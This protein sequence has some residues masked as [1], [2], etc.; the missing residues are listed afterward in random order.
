MYNIN[1]LKKFSKQAPDGPAVRIA[2]L[3]DTATQ[4]LVTAL[5]GTAF[6]RGINADIY[7]AGYDQV[8][9]EI[10]NEGSGL[11]RF[12][13]DHTIIYMSSEKLYDEYCNTPLSERSG[14]A[15][16]TMSGIASQWDKINSVIQTKIMQ[17]NFAE[18]NDMIFGSL[19]SKTEESYIY[20][21]RK[22]NYLLMEKASKVRNAYIVDLSGIQ[23]L[24]GRENLLSEKFYYSARL[25]INVESLP[26][27]A[28]QI[29]D[30]VS[31][32][33]GRFRKCVILD[34]DNT[35]WGG[36]IGDDGINNIQIGELGIGRAFS[37]LQKW[38]K[39]LKNRG[40]LLA[41]CSK[42][43]E[44]TA[45]EPFVKHPEMVLRLDDFAVFVANWEDKASN[46]RRIQQTLNIGMDSIVFIDDNPFERNLVRQMIPEITVPELPEDPALYLSFL[47][48]EN[49]FETASFSSE[50]PDRTRQYQAEAQRV[51]LQNNFTTIDDYLESL[52]MTG[53]AKPFDAFNTPRI[54][55]L[56]QRSNQF[57]LRTVRYT[58]AEISE[59]AASDK[60]ITLYFTLKDK[61]GDYGLISV[62][63]LE[64]QGSSLFV[65]TWLMSCRVL[66]R[67]VEEYVVNSMIKAAR[68]NGFS[69]ITGEYIPTP[70]NAMVKDIYE[71][72]G[73]VRTGENLF[74][75]AVDDFKPNKCFIKSE[76]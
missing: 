53:A 51:Q 29:I 74:E 13:P 72:M 41:V 36:V 39:E 44:D 24:R 20:Q 15:E 12:L 49:L 35:L 14:F 30:A 19:G 62:V 63:I 57:N 8:F 21:L 58:E 28:S 26:Y 17:F 4:L 54:S 76:D 1:Q 18:N 31:A 69:K 73:F 9:F 60:Y 10:I 42:N 45:K 66:K 25:A 65:N 3:G 22:L 6:S 46:I 11:Y 52:D 61:F 68:E 27:I 37:D 47:R 70:K 55:Q 2:V 16:K 5:K 67:T 43:N 7:E 64:K 71:K 38:I 59:I 33:S 48:S 32:F 40:V 50:D 56:T 75:A 23:N 34:L